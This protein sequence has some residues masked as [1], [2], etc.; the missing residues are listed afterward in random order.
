M[1]ATISTRLALAVATVALA[2]LSV[3]P[4]AAQADFGFT[5][6]PTGFQV[7]VT[8]ATWSQTVQAG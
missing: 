4:A 1:R 8:D 3:A 5:P 2:A 7:R 6:G